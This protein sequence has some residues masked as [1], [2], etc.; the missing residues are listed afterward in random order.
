[1]RLNGRTW[2]SGI[3]CSLSALAPVALALAAPPS[4][5]T[6]RPTPNPSQSAFFESRIRPLL[7]DR[8][9]KCHGDKVQQGNLRLDTV[10]GFRKGSQSGPVVDA[11]TPLKSRI[12][13]AIR[14]E[15]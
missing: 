5:S 3:A 14:H 10:E 2:V 11:N 9:V 13:L 15:D 12:L 4:Q 6:S 8:C 1:M 7:L